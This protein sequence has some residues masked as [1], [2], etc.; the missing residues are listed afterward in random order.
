MGSQTTDFGGSIGPTW[1]A[2][3][4]PE[5]DRIK[6]F[7]TRLVTDPAIMR[8][9]VDTLERLQKENDASRITCRFIISEDV[10]TPSLPGDI[11]AEIPLDGRLEGYR[12][13][14]YGDI[15]EER[16]PSPSEIEVQ[17]DYLNTS[18]QKSPDSRLEKVYQEELHL[19]QNP[20][21]NETRINKML[22]LYH[23]VYN[24]Y[25]FDFTD[26]T[27][28]DFFEDYVILGW[29]GE[30]LVSTYVAEIADITIETDDDTDTFRMAELSDAAVDE[31]YA[32]KGLFVASG[33]VL[34]KTLRYDNIDLVY[35]EARSS[36]VAVNIGCRMMGR[37]YAGTLPKHCTIGGRSEFDEDGKYES[38]NIWYITQEDLRGSV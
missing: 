13:I 17:Q 6:G 31:N 14:Y 2:K 12:V 24:D 29:D 16:M 30:R 35:G 18:L 27:I 28:Q 9:S 25:P 38:L 21:L 19:S 1:P 4:E 5:N 26:D 10:D 23:S 7:Q 11:E 36:S 32:S 22:Q 3:Y 8:N 20:K 15:I 37:K 33:E 34:L